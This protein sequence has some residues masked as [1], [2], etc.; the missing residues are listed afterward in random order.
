MKIKELLES[1]QTVKQQ[2]D[3]LGIDH[4]MYESNGIINLSQIVLAKKSRG[5]GIGSQAM[6]L[7]TKYAD[8]TNQT[9][10]LTP[11]K[12][13]GASSV[14]RLVE[15][16]KKFGFVLNKGKN[17]NYQIS[18]V[19][20]RLPKSNQ[21]NEFLEP[22]KPTSLK[23]STISKAGPQG[24]TT[25]I[26]QLKFETEKGNTVK[27]HINPSVVN[28]EKSIDVSFYVNDTMD[29]AASNTDHA[30]LPQVF[31]SIFKYANNAKINHI[32]FSAIQSPS[33]TKR[34][35]NIPLTKTGVTL[36]SAIDKLATK[37]KTTTITPEMQQAE[38]DRTNAI[39]AKLKRPLQTSVTVIHIDEL[40]VLLSQLK[41]FTAEVDTTNVMQTL[42]QYNHIVDKIQTLNKGINKWSEYLELDAAM[43]THRDTIKSYSEQGV[44]VTKN[45]RFSI[46]SKILQKYFSNWDVKTV[47]NSFELTRK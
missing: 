44:Q 37:L 2:W 35:K 23:R 20:Y 1:I 43:S 16:Y 33:D 6:Q 12:D 21:L 24:S 36:N 22:A 4:F 5:S 45:R 41:Q 42:M 13:F 47:G 38:L 25:K 32:T 15:F 10:T 27:I 19:M 31:Y 34:V 9:I 30:I 18:E 8:D 3:N 14:T 26:T 46:Y 39:L 7:L 40:L 29:D 17:K 11:S 28:D